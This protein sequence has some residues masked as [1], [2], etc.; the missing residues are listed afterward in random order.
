MEKLPEPPARFVARGS[1]QTRVAGS[2]LWRIYFRS[3]KHPTRWDEFRY[4]GPTSS[5][6]DHH[7]HPKRLQTRGILYATSGNDAILTALAE[8]FQDTRHVDRK[9]NRPWLV[10][11]DLGAPLTLLDTGGRW[12]VRAGGN[13]AINLGSRTKSRAWSRTIYSSYPNAEGIWYPSS[14]TNLRCAALYER[15]SHALPTSP[16][17]NEPLD[18]PKLLGGLLQLTTKLGYTLS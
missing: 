13:M 9:R 1:F 15:A 3:G 14:V 5:R 16:A 2:R 17:L 11:F 7:T 6:F 4:F 8:V 18:S 12:P 10:A